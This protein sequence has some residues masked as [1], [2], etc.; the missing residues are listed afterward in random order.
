MLSIL[1]AG[2]IPLWLAAACNDRIA[3]PLS[4]NVVPNDMNT[5]D[6]EETAVLAVD[7]T[8]EVA[9]ASAGNSSVQ[10]PRKDYGKWVRRYLSRCGLLPMGPRPGWSE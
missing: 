1:L 4:R 6:S 10:V 8:T 3:K 9:T 5:L 7:S 2:A